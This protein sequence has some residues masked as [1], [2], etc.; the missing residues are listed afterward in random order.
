MCQMTRRCVVTGVGVVSSVGIGKE[1]FWDSLVSGRSGITRVTHF[2]TSDLLAHHA[3]EVKDFTPTDYLDEL[4]VQMNGRCVHYAVAAGKI[5]LED[6]GIGAGT[7]PKSRLSVIGG[8]TAPSCDSIEKHLLTAL[9]DDPSNLPPYTLASIAVH[10]A[11]TVLSQNLGIFD[12]AITIST[13][14]TSGSNAL[15]AALKEIRSGRKDVVLSGSTENTLARYTYSSYIAAGMLVQDDDIPP[16]KVMRPFDKNRRGGVMAEGS[17]FLVLEE[18]E[19]A[20]SRGAHIYGEIVGYSFKDKFMG[21][22]S[23]YVTMAGAIQGAL[24]D[25]QMLPDGVDLVCANGS[26]MVAQDKIE[27]L[28]LKDI[29]RAQAYRIPVSAIKSMIGIP[30]SAIGPMQLIAALLSFETDMIPPTINYETPDPECDLDYVPNRARCNRVTGALINN[31]GLDG[32]CAALIAKRYC[33]GG[34]G[35]T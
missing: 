17:A 23:M 3:G 27:T 20:R 33:N 24:A 11:T 14:C 29:F 31:L 21:P 34:N 18:L 30:N 32:A 19:H 15:G 26:S 6:A 25:A 28:V 35:R 12:S 13:H 16:E 7:V 9:T 22:R 5:A 10:T 1:A 4:Q 8:T 2:D